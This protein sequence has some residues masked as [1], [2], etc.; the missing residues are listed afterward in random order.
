MDKKLPLIDRLRIL[1]EKA[2]LKKQAEPEPDS[3]SDSDAE[4]TTSSDSESDFSWMEYDDRELIE[5]LEN[6]IYNF[7]YA[8]GSMNHILDM[9]ELDIEDYRQKKQIYSIEQ[10]MTPPEEPIIS[11]SKTKSRSNIPIISIIGV[12]AAVTVFNYSIK[13]L[14]NKIFK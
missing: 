9:L 11:D 3:D 1:R 6:R 14:C 12:W 2:I 7:K 5:S 10:L 13:L 4:S 8:Y